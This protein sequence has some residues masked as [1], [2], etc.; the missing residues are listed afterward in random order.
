MRRGGGRKGGGGGGGVE[1]WL[2]VRRL[3]GK[4]GISPVLALTGR[5][6]D[7]DC[8][9]QVPSALITSSLLPFSPLGRHSVSDTLKN[10]SELYRRQGKTDTAQVLAQF[11]VSSKKV[12]QP[13]TALA[14]TR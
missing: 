12:S 6:T 7:S 3:R 10:L 9:V 8:T 1:E 13:N 5:L 4:E 14:C 2:I 11:A